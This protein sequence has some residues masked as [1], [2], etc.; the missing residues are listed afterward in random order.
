MR[1]WRRGTAGADLA[2]LAEGAAITERQLHRRFVQAVGYGPK[3]LQRVLRFQ[4]FLAL[5]RAQHA[6]LAAL[7]LRAGYADQ[8]HL[9][10]EARILAG[11]SPAQLRAARLQ[12]RNVQDA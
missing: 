4:S 12:V 5:C 10:R 7:A 6:G 9:S 11:R 1:L 3:R 8:A 2:A